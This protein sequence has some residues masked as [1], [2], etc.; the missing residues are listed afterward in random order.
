MW[1]NS[2]GGAGGWKSR[3]RAAGPPRKPESSTAAPR[4]IT[5]IWETYHRGAG[6]GSQRGV[7]LTASFSVQQAL[8]TIGRFRQRA[9][10][11]RIE[12]MV[13]GEASLP[14]PRAERRRSCAKTPSGSPT[15][16]RG[17]ERACPASHSS[18]RAF[19]RRPLTSVSSAR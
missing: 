3:W 12:R 1:E 18:G 2:A 7:S 5:A 10:I 15:A 19:S 14:H 4:S 8:A 17:D 11:V 9:H 13:I 6:G 16:G